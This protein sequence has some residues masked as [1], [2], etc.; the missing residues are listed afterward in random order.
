MH[1]NSN[2][3]IETLIS[4]LDNSY[5]IISQFISTDNFRLNMKIINNSVTNE[6][7]NLTKEESSMIVSE[8]ILFGH[9][10]NSLHNNRTNQLIQQKY[11]ILKSFI[12]KLLKTYFLNILAQS[13]QRNVSHSFIHSFIHSFNS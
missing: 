13:T 4:K 5:Q 10:M 12:N 11:P 6:S 3:P 1:S 9:L 2:K 7:T 8:S